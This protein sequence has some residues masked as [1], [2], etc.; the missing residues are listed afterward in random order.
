MQDAFSY[1]R[2]GKYAMESMMQCHSVQRSNTAAASPYKSSSKR[3]MQSKWESRE[4]VERSAGVPQ[5]SMQ[6]GGTLSRA[7]TMQQQ[8]G[9]G[10]PMKVPQTATAA[11]PSSGGFMQGVASVFG[12]ASSTP[13][14]DPSGASQQQQ[15]QQAVQ[16]RQ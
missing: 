5:T 12:C 1:E 9:M 4:R 15:Q 6:A 10:S 11:A 8:R 14:S 7:K 13:V 16:Q 3:A 2:G